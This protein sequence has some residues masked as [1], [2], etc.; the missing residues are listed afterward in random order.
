[1]KFTLIILALI[2]SFSI[3]VAQENS[4]NKTKKIFGEAV[5]YHD[6]VNGFSDKPG[7]T[8][9]DVFIQVPYKSVQFVK[10]SVGFTAK[11]SVTASVFDSSKSRL[12][13][14]K[15]WNETINVMDFSL[16]TT[17]DN[18]NLSKRSFDLQPGNYIIRTALEDLDSRKL[19]SSENK[20]VVR[21]LN[22][23]LVLS[24][25]LLISKPGANQPENKIIPNIG[26]NVSNSKDQIRMY[27]EIN[28]RDSVDISK[29]IEYVVL[30]TDNQV[31]HKESEK[32]NL[33]PGISKVLYIVS[34]FPF[35]MGAYLLSVSVKDESG[36]VLTSV[37]KSFYSQIKGLPTI[38]TDIDKA[39]AQTV[40]I[41]SS[42]EM[43][44]MQ[45]DE[46]TSEKTKRF[47]EFWKKKDPSPN[48]EENEVFDE[49]FRRVAFAN[50]NFSNYFE[51]WRTDRGMVFI[52]LGAPNNVDRHPFEYDSKPYEVW[53]YYDLNRSFI[54]LD[55]TGFGDY[56]LITPLSGDLYRYRY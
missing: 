30:N 53:E 54:F 21:D 45:E 22:G 46:K 20:L 38:I 9:V 12:I 7:L 5:F 18:F 11:Y 31:I 34:E 14:E 47:L 41:A 56:R 23:G 48:N 51:G 10:S 17:R 32:R 27:Y 50:E 42:A 15:T 6:F 49:Y 55:Q 29:S 28:N 13:V 1:M 8:K 40:Y 3:I 52:I 24:D 39:I 26:R 35:D 2:T 37:T 25:I 16:V 36:K 44:Y 43:N 19:T 33:K 4:D